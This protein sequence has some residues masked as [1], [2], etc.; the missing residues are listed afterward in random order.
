MN[1]QRPLMMSASVACCALA[2]VATTTWSMAGSAASAATTA[3]AV[4][5]QPA[6]TRPAQ[7]QPPAAHLGDAIPV[8]GLASL[9]ADGAADVSFMNCPSPGFCTAAG[10]YRDSTGHDQA[11]VVNEVDFVWGNATPVPGLAAL[12]NDGTTTIT[13]LSCPTAGNCMVGGWFADIDDNFQPFVAESTNGVFGDALG[14]FTVD[15]Q[16][17]QGI[18][19]ISAVSC[20]TPGNCTVA[21]SLPVVRPG[22]GAP[23]AVA[24]LATKTAAGGWGPLRAVP[25]FDGSSANL[26]TGIDSVSC[27]N[28][29]DCMAVG[30]YTVNGANRSNRQPLLA[31]QE[32]GNWSSENTIPGL[33]GPAVA[34]F[35]PTLNAEGVQ[36]SCWA[37]TSC[38]VAGGYGD[39]DGHRQV[40]VADWVNGSWTT[41]TIPGT[42]ELNAFGAIASHTLSCG[43]AGNCAVAGFVFTGPVNDPDSEAQAFVDSRVAGTWGSAQEIAGIDNLP[44]SDARAI[45]CPS[46]GSCVVGG[47]YIGNG[48]RAYISVENTTPGTNDVGAFGGAQEVAGNLNNGNAFLDSISCSFAG[49][50]A[51]GGAYA[52]PNG[53][54]EG[55]VAD[56]SA[57]TATT[58]SAS[59]TTVAAGNEHQVTITAKVTP[60]AGGTPTGTVTVLANGAD[61]QNTICT[62]TL[63]HR[64]GECRLPAGSLAPGNYTFFGNYNGDQVYS[65]STSSSGGG[66]TS[67]HVLSKP[68]ATSTAL[69][70]S[71]A[72]VK[73]GH[74][75]TEHLTVRVKPKTGA[76]PAGQ[77]TIKTGSTK[78]CVITLKRGTGRCTLTARKLRPGTYKLTARYGG[79][80]AHTTST[81]PKK[82]L[83]VTK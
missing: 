2:A 32:G 24:F 77:V 48:G 46:A 7:T 78:L 14:V 70:L 58:L 10:R 42:V 39:M 4:S 13:A 80:I 35:D 22:G 62:I 55:F 12:G 34:G 17:K 66:G 67:F 25:G 16:I 53:D 33:D 5:A 6:E 21:L 68:L 29:G 76:A 74:E 36:V 60:F 61:D 64:T 63:A 59:A 72:K 81:S 51:L 45:S 27:W 47:H 1:W 30:F 9:N 83:T 57:A 31:V 38:T 28:P 50:C 82:T 19:R 56:L 43:G 18:A 37:F 26:P 44:D 41:Q 69:T 20:A 79:D 8:P 3:T 73:A 71:A 40:F 54:E 49:E 11:F 75:Q 15:D 52:L 65:G 23:V